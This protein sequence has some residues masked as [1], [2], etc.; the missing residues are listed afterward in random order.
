MYFL[1]LMP[2]QTSNFSWDELERKQQIL[3]IHPQSTNC[4]NT[5]YQYRSLQQNINL[6]HIDGVQR[7]RLI[8]KQILEVLAIY[9]NMRNLDFYTRA[10]YL[11]KGKTV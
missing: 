1:T 5:Y 9:N 6:R 7:R 8:T 2:K 10:R 11:S 3:L 4:L